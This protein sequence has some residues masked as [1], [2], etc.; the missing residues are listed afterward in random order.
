MYKD[1]FPDCAVSCIQMVPARPFISHKRSVLLSSESA[2]RAMCHFHR[3]CDVPLP[4]RLRASRGLLPTMACC[5][6]RPV[7]VSFRDAEP[8][9]Q[10]NSA[11]RGKNLL[12]DGARWSVCQPCPPAPPLPIGHRHTH[13]AFMA[14]PPSG[15]GIPCTMGGRNAYLLNTR[16]FD[17]FAK[18]SQKLT[19]FLQAVIYGHPL[20]I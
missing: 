12:F 19:L 16:R 4:P 14:T 9:V 1:F 13:S 18:F 2:V 7:P 10:L 8:G 17:F 20:C 11:L 3:G 15:F 5:L 6:P